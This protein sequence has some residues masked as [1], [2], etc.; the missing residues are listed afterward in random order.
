ML[1]KI[2]SWIS[3]RR[4]NRE[5][6]KSKKKFEESNKTLKEDLIDI[7]N[8]ITKDLKKATKKEKGNI[9]KRINKLILNIV[10][11]FNT[12]KNSL[13][14]K[15]IKFKTQISQKFQTETYTELKETIL[16]IIGYGFIVF[17]LYYTLLTVK[18][19]YE[20][21]WFSI[22]HMIGGGS[23][24]YLFMDLFD[25]ILKTRKKYRKNK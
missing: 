14:L 7:Y 8:C 21:T 18:Y 4:L 9:F 13:I 1:E 16:S 17:P 11:F 3:I 5:L 10:K 12:I 15:I 25:Y 2:K 24:I 22:L 19:P 6:K 23:L 20:F